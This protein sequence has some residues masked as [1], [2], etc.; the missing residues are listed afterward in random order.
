MPIPEHVTSKPSK[1]PLYA[2]ALRIFLSE[3][4]ATLPQIALR[5]GL[6][7]DSLI[8][9]AERQSWHKRRAIVDKDASETR[10]AAASK[11]DSTLVEATA[12]TVGKMTEGWASVVDKVLLLSTEPDDTLPPKDQAR[13]HAYLLERKAD[14]MTKVSKGYAAM[15]E[16][17]SSLGLVKGVAKEGS[18]AG[19]LDLGKLTQ[20]NL[21]INAALENKKPLPVQEVEVFE[22]G[23][24]VI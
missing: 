8:A 5:V 24:D 20:L 4:G 17:A 1:A 2:E 3:P 6:R 21:T 13:E 16:T 11:V 18:E 15:I 22:L 7:A 9:N 14:L 19:K 12:Q 10:I 23:E